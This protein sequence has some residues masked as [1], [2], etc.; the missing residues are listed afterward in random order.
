MSGRRGQ[1]GPHRARRGAGVSGRRLLDRALA[2]RDRVRAPG[3]GEAGVGKTRLLRE[4]AARAPDAGFGVLTGSASSWAARAC[5]SPRWS[6]RCARS[7]GRR[8]PTSWPA[9]RPGRAASWPGCCPSSRRTPRAAGPARRRGPADG[10]AARARP[11]RARPAER[12][13]AA[14]ARRRGPALGRPVHPRPGRV[15]VRRCRARRVLLVITYR[16]DELHRRHPLR[17]LLA[18]WERLRGRRPRPAAP[19]QPRRG[20]RPARR[21]SSARTPRRGV[22]DVVFDR[23]GGNAF[24]VEELAARGARRRRPGATCRRRCATCCCAG[25]S[26]DPAAQRLLRTASVAGRGGAGPA[27]R[28]GRRVSPRPSSSRRCGRRWTNHLLRGRRQRATA[29]RSGTR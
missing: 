20:R 4:L 19:V 6:T 2:R 26:A 16:S 14:A 21:R 13:P 28:R 22:V 7:P 8:R 23:S 17:P 24:F 3:R 18:G 27:A 29:T 10:A 5:R 9:P 15:P 12:G 25:S 1:P 11:R